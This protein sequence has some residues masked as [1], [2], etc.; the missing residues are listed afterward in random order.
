MSISRF[1]GAALAASAL[2]LAPVPALAQQAKQV[3]DAN[4]TN[5]AA[6]SQQQPKTP[7]TLTGEW[8][9]LRTKLRNDGVDLTAGYTSEFAANVQGG[10]R[11]D[12]TE[13]GQ[14]TF[15]ATVDTDK[16][17]GLKGGT[18][19]ATITYRRGDDLGAHAGLN[20][21]QQ[22]Q[23]VYGRGQTWRLTELWYQQQITPTLDLKAGRLAMGTD[24]SS[25]SCDFENLS[26]CG[27][28]VGNIAG[29]YWY[30][31]PVSQWGARLRAK[32]KSWYAMIGAYENNPNNLKNDFAL[33]HGGA[34]GVLVPFEFGW[35]P[36]LGTNHLPGTYRIGGWYNSSNAVD[37]LVGDDHRPTAIT[38]LDPMDHSGRYG[39]YVLL[40]QQLTGTY[41]D[42]PVKGPSV[43][44]GLSVFVNVTQTDRNTEKTDNQVAVGATYVGPFA[45]RPKDDIGL[46]VARTNYNGRAAEAL[47]L[48]TPGTEKPDAEYEAELYY[49][50]H[51]RDW[52]VVR[53]NVQYVANP[54]GYHDARNLVV[55]GIKSGVTF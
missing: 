45:F 33:S 39:I 27:A 32:H 41:T 47:V 53:P 11:H 38:G 42:D 16:L 46:A 54:G 10:E 52:L 17:L 4:G 18:F 2:T 44:H 31:W 7:S 5:D 6:D 34:T 26:F 1:R 25:F 35:T 40:Q 22:V 51:F 49:G 37:V 55:F 13:T 43:T 21:L 36:H 48:A 28:P 3:P 15:G 30:N 29:D 23:E 9:G 14:F 20:D 50:I 12:A 8:G 24:F 19:Q